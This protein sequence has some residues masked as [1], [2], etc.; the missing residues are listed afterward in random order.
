MSERLDESWSYSAA[1]FPVAMAFAADGRTLAIGD[2]A[3]RVGWVD[4]A[5]GT[6]LARDVADR[7]GVLAFAWHPAERRL[8]VGGQGGELRVYHD[9]RASTTVGLEGRWIE[10][11][12]WDPGGER[13]AIAQG[14][15]AIVVQPDGTRVAASEPQASTL[16]GLAYRAGGRQLVT[17]CYGGVAVH[18]PRSLAVTRRFRWTG[19]LL[20]LA[21]SPNDRVV[22]CGAQDNTV[23][24]WRFADGRDAQ[25]AG[26]PLKPQSLSWSADSN[27]LATSGSEA[28]IVW[29]FDGRGPEGREPLTLQAHEA[30]VTHVSFAPSGPALVSAC[31]SGELCLWVPGA[32]REALARRRLV[33]RVAAIA[34]GVAGE[35]THLAV[36]TEDGAVRGWAL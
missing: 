31:R 22:A 4:A 18:D 32:R 2:A 11:L 25:M 19:S 12:A 20:N 28:V 17:A 30:P 36:A 5:S 1:D 7:K 35:D 21:V 24:F 9:G 26:Y 16:T 33:G 6:E 15:K 13:I 3:G 8:A 10:R 29:P 27:W 34:W 23:H 14:R